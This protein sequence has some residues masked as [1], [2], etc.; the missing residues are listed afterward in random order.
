MSVSLGYPVWLLITALAVAGGLTYWTYYNTTPALPRPRKALLGGLRFLSLA[1][2]VVLLFEPIIRQLD[3]DEVP[4]T[5]ALL[6]DNTQS[7]DPRGTTASDSASTSAASARSAVTNALN[8]IDDAATEVFFFGTSTRPADASPEAVAD[9]LSFSDPRTD[10]ANALSTVQQELARDNLSGVLLISDGQYNTGR[11]PLYI[12]DRYPVPIHTVVVGDTTRQRDLQISRITTNDIAYTGTE[13]PVQVGLR[14]EDYPGE[15]VTVSL[16]KNGSVLDSES[17]N[18]PD[19]AA[20]VSVDLS[21]TPRQQGLQQF[22]VHVTELPGEVTHRNNRSTFT[23]RVLDSKKQVLLLGA[24]PGPDVATTRQLLENAP[25]I[26]VQS[27]I[28]KSQGAFYEGELPDTFSD[29]D[30]IVL[31]GYPGA[32]ADEATMDRL[33]GAIADDDLPILFLLTRQTDLE[34]LSTHFREVLPAFP[35]AVRPGFVPASMVL[36]TAG[37]QHPVLELPVTEPE[38]LPSLPPLFYNE[39]RWQTSPDASVLATTQVRGID[40]KDPLLVVRRRSGHRSAAFLGAGTWRW[41]N[42]PAGLEEAAPFWPALFS[43]LLQ[44][45]STPANDRRVRVQP[46]REVFAGGEAV[47]FTG[48]V[49]NESLDPVENASV[50]LH[51]EAPDGARYPYNMKAVGNGRYTL[52]IGSLPE[53]TY[54]YTATATQEGD[55]L[56][57]DQGS[58]AIGQLS[59]EFQ[60]TRAN[61]GLMRQ[62]AQRSG[63]SF[64]LPDSLNRLSQQLAQAGTFEASYREETTET[65]LWHLYGLLGVIMVLLT[66]EWFFRKRSGMV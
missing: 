15:F 35:E 18:L 34:A 58:F 66:A 55:T 42:L 60:E 49:Y 14:V 50:N 29:V 8:H 52:E 53:G 36:T 64:F 9:S 57:S 13:L 11:N 65:R 19:G 30:A 37:L 23:V 32:M 28:Q 54:S 2:L 1:L 26:T 21:F 59:L 6:V 40:L 44:W 20:Q 39:S 27:Y 4:P 17:V 31:A 48:Q 3:R 22:Q 46:T 47:S 56:G 7:L 61:V 25:N 51:L 41:Q 24:A 12:A 38:L 63:G 43:N 5:L 45:T 16:S 62:I 33:S 10:I